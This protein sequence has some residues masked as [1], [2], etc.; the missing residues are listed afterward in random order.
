MDLRARLDEL[1]RRP[2]DAASIRRSMR[3]RLHSFKTGPD[4]QPLQGL[5]VGRG[6][7]F[8]VAVVDLWAEVADLV[9]F[10]QERIANESYI[11]TAQEPESV[12]RLARQVGYEPA[13]GTAART[14]VALQ[15]EKGATSNVRAGTRVQSK[16][17]DGIPAKVFETSEDAVA[18]DRFASMALAPTPPLA[19]D[20]EGRPALSL[21]IKGS[22]LTLQGGEPL[23]F[24]PINL[25]WARGQLRVVSSATEG[26]NSTTIKWD[27]PFADD[28]VADCADG[29]RVLRFRRTVATYSPPAPPPPVEVR[30]QSGGTDRKYTV[31]ATPVAPP[32]PPRVPPP[33]AGLSRFIVDG[34][35]DLPLAC[36]WVAV[37]EEDAAAPSWHCVGQHM[38]TRGPT[39]LAPISVHVLDLTRAVDTQPHAVRAGVARIFMDPGDLVLLPRYDPVKKGLTVLR[40]ATPVM[41]PVG[42]DVLLAGAF[43]DRPGETWSSVV[44]VVAPEPGLKPGLVRLAEGPPEDLEAASVTLTGNLV[45][46]THG[47]SVAPEKWL[48]PVEGPVALRLGHPN[49]T[50]LA[51]GGEARASTLEVRVDGRTWRPM[52]SLALAGAMDQAYAS[53]VDADGRTTILFGDG[54]HGMR[55]PG[56]TT[57]EA[58]YRVGLGRAGNVAAGEVCALVDSPARLQRARNV[59]GGAGGADAEDT[60]SVRRR[61]GRSVRALGQLVSLRDYEDAACRLAGIGLARASATLVD[62]RRVVEVVVAG[63]PQPDKKLQQA[64]AA[65][66]DALGDP[67][68]TVR[69][70][71]PEFVRVAVTARL[72]ITDAREGARVQA[73]GVAAIRSLF[74]EMG[75][76]VG[77][78]LH[79]SRLVAC[80]Q[81]VTGVASVELTRFRKDEAA[82]PTLS[83]ALAFEGNQVASAGEIV[84]D[85]AEARHDV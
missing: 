1:A 36:P 42:T 73:A 43:A 25:D 77:Q 83:G 16:A 57:I 52:A 85:V 23:L 37:S 54:R 46:A 4:E 78:P 26:A 60:S 49:L 47:E 31:S 38:L 40:L 71:A 65:Y 41:I 13:P 68:V 74:A 64:V 30:I 9:A 21:V 51:R 3:R 18:D 63:T 66:L 81:R 84:V 59:A 50:H 12:L 67:T 69:V 15:P 33:D 79:A 17:K 10:Y 39:D 34:R 8:A 2:G 20:P 72:R 61:A 29:L 6:D 55:P 5:T 48:A 80:L 35:F 70:V 14:I 24:L 32:A 28:F 7:D 53:R 44:R 75:S 76:D 62:G 27:E 82:Q 56:G 19:R 22:R 45:S 11:R 58:R